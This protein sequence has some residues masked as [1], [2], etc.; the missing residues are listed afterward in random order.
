LP[1]DIALNPILRARV[2]QS[3]TE[4][5]VSSACH[6][7]VVICLSLPGDKKAE[8]VSNLDIIGKHRTGINAL[9]Y[10]RLFFKLRDCLFVIY[11][12]DL[13]LS[14]SHRPYAFHCT[15]SGYRRFQEINQFAGPKRGMWNAMTWRG[16]GGIPRC[17]VARSARA[18]Y[19]SDASGTG[20]F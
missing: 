20:L 1:S 5:S 2:K 14:A 4:H 19:A 7:G 17:L 3:K 12:V 16:K 10:I 8:N 9:S 11:Y 18:R 13:F 15:N 6:V